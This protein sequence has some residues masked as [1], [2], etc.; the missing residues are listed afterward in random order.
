[1]PNKVYTTSLKVAGLGEDDDRISNLTTFEGYSNSYILNPPAVGKRTFA[2]P[3]K[4]VYKYLK[5]TAAGYGN[6]SYV[7]TST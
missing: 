1:M 4:Q 3:I 5:G 7:F 2:D 6:E